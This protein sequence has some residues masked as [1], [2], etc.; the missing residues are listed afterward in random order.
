ME[1]CGQGTISYSDECIFA[2]RCNNIE[3]INCRSKKY[4]I[5][6]NKKIPISIIAIAFFITIFGIEYK[7]SY[8]EKMT[9]HFMNLEK[10]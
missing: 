1:I 3:I 4:A 7:T 6:N 10:K 8:W 5:F 2:T 9:N